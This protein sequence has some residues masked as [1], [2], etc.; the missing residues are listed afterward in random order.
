MKTSISSLV[1][2]VLLGTVCVGCNSRNYSGDQRFPLSGKVT[3]NGEEVD[4]GSISFL[5]LNDAKQRV[6]GG[7]ITDGAYVVDEEYGANAGRYRVEIRWQKK[8]GEKFTDGFGN[9]DDVRVEGIPSEFNSASTLT[10]E[11]G[12]GQTTF[13]FDLESEKR[14]STTKRRNL[15]GKPPY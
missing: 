2:I 5:P 9:V 7:T 11:V 15:G 6:S 14:V 12:S 10:A 8:T 4:V 1:H 3:Y 13:D